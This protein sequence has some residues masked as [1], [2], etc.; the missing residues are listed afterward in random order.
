MATITVQPIS[1]LINSA[2]CSVV[3]Q[4]VAIRKGWNDDHLRAVIVEFVT[5][6]NDVTLRDFLEAA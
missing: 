5:C 1:M 2:M 3:A 4:A 6:S